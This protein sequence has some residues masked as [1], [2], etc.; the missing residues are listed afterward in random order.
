MSTFNWGSGGP[1]IRLIASN[2]STVEA[3]LYLP[4][5][6]LGGI[7]QSFDENKQVDEMLDGTMNVT[8]KGYYHRY[9]VKW[10]V[11]DETTT[12]R[13]VGILDGNTPTPDQLV[14]I[15]TSYRPGR[16][17]F[18]PSESGTLYSVFLDKLPKVLP[19]SD[20]A[21]A[22]DFEVKTISMFTSADNTAGKYLA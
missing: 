18:S 15:L 16:L 11:Y 17:Q 9:A 22:F 10:D 3:T 6:A 4:A 21:T 1:R 12:G 5:P 13:T 8:I 20:Y 14:Q 19:I 2:G 7:T